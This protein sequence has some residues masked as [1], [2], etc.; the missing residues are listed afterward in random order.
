[1]IYFMI[2]GSLVRNV[3]N[4]YTGD[5]DAYQSSVNVPYLGHYCSWRNGVVLHTLSEQ[6][7][8][9]SLYPGINMAIAKFTIEHA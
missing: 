5:P 9:L 4:C 8:K 2:L 3:K 6:K 7:K 1:M